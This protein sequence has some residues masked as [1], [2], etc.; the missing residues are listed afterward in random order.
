[1]PPTDFATLTRHLTQVQLLSGQLHS[2]HTAAPLLWTEAA[3]ARQFDLSL[4]V[5]QVCANSHAR[6]PWHLKYLRRPQA[7]GALMHDDGW[8]YCMAVAL[9]MG[10]RCVQCVYGRV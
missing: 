2:L 9:M 4:G 8:A 3:L 1:M 5:V 10:L 7:P 6:V